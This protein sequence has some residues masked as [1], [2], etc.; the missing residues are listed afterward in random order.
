MKL[1]RTI[2]ADM[3]EMA[4]IKAVPYPTPRSVIDVLLLPGTWAVIN[5]R[6]ASRLHHLGLTPLSRL[7]Y[8]LNVVLFSFDVPPTTEIGPGMV[9]PHPMGVAIDRAAK[10]GARNRFLRSVAIGGSGDPNRPGAPTSGDDVWFMDA[11]HVFGPI[12]IG[13]RSILGAVS[14]VTAD[15]PPDMFVFG[16]RKT[17]DMKSL[18]ELGLQ[19]HHLRDS[20]W[21]LKTAG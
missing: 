13:D 21:T 11:C 16:Q 14:M 20:A 19:D 1:F 5:Y 18:T 2:N 7:L 4:T 3:R 15:V 6:I 12:H 17:N 8:F 9:V 10:L